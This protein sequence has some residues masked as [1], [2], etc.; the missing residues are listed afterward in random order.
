ML[1]HESSIHKDMKIEIISCFFWDHNAM[2]VEIKHKNKD[3]KCTHLK[4]NQY[5]IEWVQ[6]E[7]REVIKTFLETKKARVFRTYENS[8][9]SMRQEI[10]SM[11]FYQ[12]IRKNP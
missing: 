10:H 6:E 11:G 12:E 2:K 4:I 3:E 5:A 7:I 1:K 9:S 8:K